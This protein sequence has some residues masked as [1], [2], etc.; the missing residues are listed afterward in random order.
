[1][2]GSFSFPRLHPFLPFSLIPNLIADGYARRRQ[3]L[4]LAQFPPP[5]LKA[6]S[7]DL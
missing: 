5:S 6:L 1:M 4:P 7:A 3:I 2:E